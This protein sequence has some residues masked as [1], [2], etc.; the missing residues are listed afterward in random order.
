M[1]I[2][3]YQNDNVDSIAYQSMNSSRKNVNDIGKRNH[4]W[5]INENDNETK[6]LRLL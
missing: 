4:Y 2:H 1:F 6:D 3:I 5:R